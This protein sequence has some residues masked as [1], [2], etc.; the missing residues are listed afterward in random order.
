MYR[1]GLV[2]LAVSGLAWCSFIRICSII[3]TLKSITVIDD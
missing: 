2:V 1:T 3:T